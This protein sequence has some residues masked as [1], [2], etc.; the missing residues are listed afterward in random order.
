MQERILTALNMDGFIDGRVQWILSGSIPRMEKVVAIGIIAK[1][2]GAFA[3]FVQRAGI[4]QAKMSSRF[5]SKELRL[6][7]VQM[8][9]SLIGGTQAFR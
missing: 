3:E 6:M 4:S 5:F 8:L 2:L 1:V 9:G 7:G